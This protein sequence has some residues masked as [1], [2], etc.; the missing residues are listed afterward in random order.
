MK[1]NN[2]S[3]TTKPAHFNG[4]DRKWDEFYSQLRTYLLA[5]DWL[6]ITDYF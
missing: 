3:D 2:S 1:D 4:S 5:K 6:T